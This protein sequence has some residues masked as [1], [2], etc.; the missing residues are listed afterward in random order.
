MVAR[1]RVPDSRDESR[2]PP[3]GL[4]RNSRGKRN[5]MMPLRHQVHLRGGALLDRERT[6]Q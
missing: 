5:T 4:G 6:V 3:G 1:E 2:A